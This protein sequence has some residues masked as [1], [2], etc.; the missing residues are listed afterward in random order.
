[1]DWQ[2]ETRNVMNTEINFANSH[3]EYNIWLKILKGWTPMEDEKKNYDGN[4]VY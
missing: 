4:A 3:T 1:M 2:I